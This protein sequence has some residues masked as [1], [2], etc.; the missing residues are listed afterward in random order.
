VRVIHRG[1]RCVP[2]DVYSLPHPAELL[3]G[4]ILQSTIGGLSVCCWLFES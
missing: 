1:L 3:T 4:P 2:A